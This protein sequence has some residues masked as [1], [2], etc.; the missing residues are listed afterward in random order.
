MGAFKCP[1]C[2]NSTGGNEQFCNECGQALNIVCQ[3]C[4]QKW[5]FMFDHKFCP[6]CGHN[7]K[8]GNIQINSTISK[9]INKSNKE[10]NE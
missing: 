6:T 9:P 2:G 7:M 1:K 4:S 5:R 10:K 3:K 8:S